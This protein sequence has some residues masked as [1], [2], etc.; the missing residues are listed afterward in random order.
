MSGQPYH[1]VSSLPDCRVDEDILSRFGSFN[2]RQAEDDV[3]GLSCYGESVVSLNEQE[4]GESSS[5]VAGRNIT[6]S[7]EKWKV[8]NECVACSEI[9]DT[10]QVS[11]QHHYCKICVIRLVS[12]SIVDESLF[13]PR[14][15]GQEMPMSLLR[16]YITAELTAKFELTAIE[17]GTPYRTYCYSCGM[18]ISP[19]R[20]Q[21][22]QAHCT[23]CNLDTCILC[24]GQFHDGDSEKS[25][26]GGVPL[27]CTR[28]R[29]ATMHK[30]SDHD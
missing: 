7:K 16:P 29:L 9:R 22:H 2:L 27:A 1:H 15:C 8:K 28:D 18:F 13:R 12:D 4:I 5:W 30:L 3:D 10:M 11:C 24:N 6:K 19:D 21:G 23:T 25:S 14:C 17:F 26:S 20:I